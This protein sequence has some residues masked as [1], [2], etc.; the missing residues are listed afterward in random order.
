MLQASKSLFQA[1]GDK[2]EAALSGAARSPVV[3]K[4]PSI[5]ISQNGANGYT[6]QQNEPR[7]ASSLSAL[8]SLSLEGRIGLL[9]GRWA[10]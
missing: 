2:L 1:L 7:G 6:H 8:E 3:G 9:H 4:S 10:P 5:C